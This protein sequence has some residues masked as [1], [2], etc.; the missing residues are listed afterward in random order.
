MQNEIQMRHWDLALLAWL[1]VPANSA[2]LPAS[3]VYPC[4]GHYKG[5]VS[6]CEEGL[7]WRPPS[8]LSPWVQEGTR[9]GGTPLADRQRWLMEFQAKGLRSVREVHLRWKTLSRQPTGGGKGRRKVRRDVLG[10]ELARDDVVDRPDVDTAPMTARQKGQ[11]RANLR[12]YSRRIFVGNRNEAVSM[13]KPFAV[14]VGTC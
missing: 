14:A 4:I 7:G 3:Y 11:R 10:V 8:W 12:D 6:G 5:H 13:S 9:A 1:E 2:R